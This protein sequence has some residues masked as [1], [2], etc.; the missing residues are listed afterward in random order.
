MNA[1]DPVLWIFM[2]ERPG[3]A[4]RLE[5]GQTIGRDADNAIV[6]EHASVSRQHAR[7]VKGP[8]G[9]ELENLSRKNGIVTDGLSVERLLLKDHA[10]FRLGDVDVQFSA[11]ANADLA[12]INERRAASA[13]LRLEVH[14]VDRDALLQ[15]VCAAFTATAEC[16]RGL[17]MLGER[18]ALTLRASVGKVTADAG[19]GALM[20]RVMA[21]NAPILL[22]D[23]ANAATL[24]A[25]PS[26]LQQRI[27]AMVCYPLRQRHGAL[28]VLY[29]DST[30]VG[31]RFTELDAELLSALA[32]DAALLIAE[33]KLA[34]GLDAA[35]IDLLAQQR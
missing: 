24:R 18:G 12:L 31:K 20:D 23:V 5:D 21:N 28:G 3:R 10:W 1:P 13:A 34:A 35:L 30:E 6:L 17:L 15:R 11:Q 32:D 22:S 19:S 27:A 9:F 4:Y 14:Q 26:V 25:R 16:S 33:A 7:M 8:G 29:A 2:P